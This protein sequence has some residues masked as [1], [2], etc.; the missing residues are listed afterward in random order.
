MATF[1]L[2]EAPD[3]LG[4]LADIKQTPT[5]DQFCAAMIGG[6]VHT[7]NVLI[8]CKGVVQVIKQFFQTFKRID[9]TKF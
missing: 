4:H 5:G 6:A 3:G 2:Y 9:L 8:I 1:L 7:N